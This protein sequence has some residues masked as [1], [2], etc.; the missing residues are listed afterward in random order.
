MDKVPVMEASRVSTH[1]KV[2][3]MVNNSLMDS[4]HIHLREPLQ[5]NIPI[6]CRPVIRQ[7]IMTAINR[8]INSKINKANMGNSH[9]VHLLVN[10]QDNNKDPMVDNI[11]RRWCLPSMESRKRYA[12]ITIPNMRGR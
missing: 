5:E 10:T 7:E 4:N 8:K 2:D 3:I 11:R 12:N 1:H 9:L 6:R